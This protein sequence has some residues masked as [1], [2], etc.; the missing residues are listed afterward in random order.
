MTA[1]SD[2]TKGA[3]NNTGFVGGY[4]AELGNIIGTQFGFPRVDD[5]STQAAPLPAD[6]VIAPNSDCV[7]QIPITVSGGVITETSGGNFPVD[8]IN[9]GSVTTI[10]G[11]ALPGSETLTSAG[12]GANITLS[13]TPADGTYTAAFVGVPAVVSASSTP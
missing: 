10:T 6:N 9:G 1:N 7:A 4:D 11:T 2:I 3:D 13:T 12:G 5:L 8:L